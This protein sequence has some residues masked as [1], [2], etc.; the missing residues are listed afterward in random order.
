MKKT[1]CL[2][3]TCGRTDGLTLI[4]EKTSLLKLKVTFIL[5]LIFSVQILATFATHAQTHILLLFYIE[6][7]QAAGIF[8]INVCYIFRKAGKQMYFFGQSTSKKNK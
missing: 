2:V 4:I 6:V 1:N 8:F 5:Y 7:L 3:Q